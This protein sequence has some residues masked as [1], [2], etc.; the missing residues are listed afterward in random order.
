MFNGKYISIEYLMERMHR[1]NPF[2]RNKLDKY[3]VAEYIYDAMLAI[4]VTVPYEHKTSKIDVENYRA[5]LPHNILTI[6]GIRRT[7]DNAPMV[8]MTGHYPTEEGDL[9]NPGAMLAYRIEGNYIFVPI[10]E[11]EEAIEVSAKVFPIDNCNL[12]KIPD[13]PRYLKAIIS[14]IV[15][16]YGF[17]MWMSD[18]LPENK[19]RELERDWLF[20]VKSAANEMRM[21][22]YDEAE[23]LKAQLQ[24]MIS[25]SNHHAYG[26]KYLNSPE[27]LNTRP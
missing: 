22:G 23:S 21:P 9:K 1:E 24:R 17:I 8:K 5:E 10:E 19:Y 13:S 16:R 6:E 2:L 26:F 7:S 4:G 12:P 11:G 14:Y 20:Y 25:S 18:E 15:E 27:K 3:E